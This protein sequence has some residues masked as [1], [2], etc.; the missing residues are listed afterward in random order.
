MMQI[1]E[2]DQKKI[3]HI[4]VLEDEVVAVFKDI[5]DGAII[6]CTTGFGGHSEAILK[7]NKNI[8]LI[9]NDR[10]IEALNFSKTRLDPFKDRITFIHG[11]FGDVLEKISN[12]DEIRG[13]LADIGVSSYQIDNRDRGF[14][15]ESEVLDMRMDKNTQLNAYD[16]I[17]YYSLDE[18]EN[19]FKNYGEIREYK[20][21]ARAIIEERK[22]EKIDSCAK[23]ARVAAKNIRGGKI[24]PATLLF[25]AVRIEVNRELEQL[26]KLLDGVKKLKACIVAIISFHSLEDRIVKDAFKEFE[27]SCICPSD[28][29]RCECG[30]NHQ[31]GT[32]VTKKPIIPTD[33]E[34][35]LNPRSRS[36]KLRV[37]SLD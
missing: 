30:N 13:V 15:F 37:F 24:N 10:D 1:D 36:S 29:F 22:E 27:R 23:L 26:E 34:I 16:V 6:D 4:P 32:R 7:A 28:V 17:N 33:S 21:L 19:I 2:I 11:E 3:P 18:L 31:I 20:K 25:Q 5:K 8:K 14:G 35:K 9:C 12:L